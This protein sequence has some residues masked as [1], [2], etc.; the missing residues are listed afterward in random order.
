MQI[1]FL[2]Q[3]NDRIQEDLNTKTKESENLHQLIS[4]NPKTQHKEALLK[5]YQQFYEDLEIKLKIVVDENEKLNKVLDDS[6]KDMQKLQD[7]KKE[8]KIK[9][10][11]YK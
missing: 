3:E 8:K 9:G 2:L 10:K 1:T 4:K 11:E 7:E 5:Q 6:M